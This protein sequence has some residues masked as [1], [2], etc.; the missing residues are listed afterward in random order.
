MIDMH[1]S[2]LQKKGLGDPLPCKW[3]QGS[4][5]TVDER[6]PLC[7][8]DDVPRVWRWT[9]LRAGPPVSKS[10]CLC[11]GTCP[12][13]VSLAVAADRVLV[14]PQGGVKRQRHPACGEMSIWRPLSSFSR[15][16]CL[17]TFTLGFRPAGLRL[18]TPGTAV[19]LPIVP[20]FIPDVVVL[21]HGAHTP[22]W[23]SAFS[24]CLLCK[25]RC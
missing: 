5:V 22:H 13:P 8:W 23:G 17:G 14:E 20:S 24:A 15:L 2:W 10:H 21:R 1:L 12:W 25:W 4:P 16:G 18:C 9:V 11:F 7:F 6:H 3:V 19:V